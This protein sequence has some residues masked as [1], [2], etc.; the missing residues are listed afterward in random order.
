MLKHLVDKKLCDYVAMDIKS[1][2]KGYL[3]AIGLSKFDYF[4]IDESINFL[5][6]GTVPYEFRTTVAK[7]LHTDE[8]FLSIAERIKGAR[9]YCLQNFVNSDN[10]IDK[11]LTPFSEKEL[12]KAASYF[13]GKVDEVVIR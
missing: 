12:K 11:T 3:N 13:E 10:V 1:S 4:S 7:Q 9:R 5:K 8:D 2:E 6:K